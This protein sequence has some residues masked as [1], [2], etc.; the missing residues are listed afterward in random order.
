ML[1]LEELVDTVLAEE[2]Q[3]LMGLDFLFET[4]EL[5][6]T[7][8]ERIFKK[9]LSEYSERRPMKKTEVFNNYDMDGYITMPEGCTS[10]RIARFGILPNQMPRF[11][12]PTFGEQNIEYDPSTNTVKVW[13]PITPLRLSYTQRYIA[14]KNI[15]IEQ[16]FNTSFA[17]DTLDTEL[18]TMFAGKTLTLQRQDVDANGN[19]VILSM[20]ATGEII[21]EEELGE[22]NVINKKA[23]LSGTLGTGTVNLNT[24]ELNAEFNESSTAPIILNYYP[25]Y[26]VCKEMD[27]G[28]YIFTK[29]FAS[30]LLTAL[31]SL[32]AQATQEKLHNI[33][34]TSDELL[35]RASELRTEVNRLLKS[36]WGIGTA[37]PL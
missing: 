27:I 13:P 1:Y 25:K 22:I 28:N 18:N 33:D 24:L 12:M 21:E 17:T 37:A 14:T 5:P 9:A 23:L 4:L 2:G 3:T 6:M 35:D 10:C 8:I 29:L 32:R 11:Y 34:L 20:S 31:A 30:K 7:K 15:L 16:I 36:S 26:L 19:P